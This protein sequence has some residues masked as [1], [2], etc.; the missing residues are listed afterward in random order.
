MSILIQL[1]QATVDPGAPVCVDVERI[2]AI[3]GVLMRNRAGDSMLDAEDNLR[4]AG[5]VVTVDAGSAVSYEVAETPSEILTLGT[6]AMQR[7]RGT[8]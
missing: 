2:V 8:S 5:A 3:R 4:L 1:T 7:I 6:E